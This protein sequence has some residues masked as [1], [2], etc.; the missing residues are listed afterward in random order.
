[1]PSDWELWNEGGAR[2]IVETA[3][4]EIAAVD[5]ERFS[6]FLQNAFAFYETHRIPNHPGQLASVRL[7]DRVAEEQ[8]STARF[9]LFLVGLFAGLA[10]TLAAIGIYGVISY[11]VS[12]RMHEFGMRIALGASGWNLM[13][14]VMRQGLTLTAI[15]VALGLGCALAFAGVLDS[16]L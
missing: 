7:M 10:L 13:G 5:R 12:Q 9:A 11:S 3:D 8:L 16:L 1:L 4:R 14:L 2:T 15:G 6:V